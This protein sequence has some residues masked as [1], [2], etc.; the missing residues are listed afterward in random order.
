MASLR[1]KCNRAQGPRIKRQVQLFDADGTELLNPA[2]TLRA[3]T[4]HHRTTYGDNGEAAKR[5]LERAASEVRALA[6]DG[7]GGGTPYHLR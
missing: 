6:L 1:L 5:A 3:I 4:R 2:E 7:W